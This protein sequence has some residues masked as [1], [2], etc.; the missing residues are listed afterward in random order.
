MPAVPQATPSI[1]VDAT[2]LITAFVSQEGG[3]V[4][5]GEKTTTKQLTT[6]PG[7]TITPS[8]SEQVAAT[9]QSYTTGEIKVAPI[10]SNYIDTSDANATASNILSGKTAYVNGAKVTG[11]IASK[12]SSDLTASGAKVSV[13]AGYYSAAASK[14]VATAT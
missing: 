2:G 11:N 14:S 10:P 6:Q 5:A 3:Y 7:K 8:K 12:S 9:A 13:P 4:P 1:N